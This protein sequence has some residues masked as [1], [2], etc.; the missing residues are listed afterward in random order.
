MC[1]HLFVAVGKI[2]HVKKSPKYNSEK[3]GK[4]DRELRN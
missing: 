4:R 2:L 3:G 1:R